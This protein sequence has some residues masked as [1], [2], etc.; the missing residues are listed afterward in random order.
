MLWPREKGDR[1]AVTVGSWSGNEISVGV[2]LRAG[3]YYMTDSPDMCEEPRKAEDN[4]VEEAAMHLADRKYRDGCSANGKMQIW[5]RAE[6]FV[7]QDGKLYYWTKLN[8][9]LH[10]EAIPLELKCASCA[11]KALYKIF[12]RMGLPRILTIDY[13]G[14]FCN[15]IDKNVMK[16]LGMKY[17]IIT[18]YHLQEWDT[19]L[20]TS[21]FAYN[22]AKQG[23]TH[24]CPFEL[25]FRR[26]AN[27]PVVINYALQEGEEL[28][29]D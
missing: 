26:K 19:F 13:G 10:V 12:M 1:V 15:E 28:L 8:T 20:D 4:L 7:L 27:L 23:S 29:K 3:R 6:K 2:E 16:L 5:I 14:E 9:Q 22:I 21:V 17:P 25:M 18:P 24:Y 11:T